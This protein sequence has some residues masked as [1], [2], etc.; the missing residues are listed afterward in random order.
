MTPRTEKRRSRP[1]LKLREVLCGRG[2]TSR[3]DGGYS[4]ETVLVIALLAVLA[5]GAVTIISQAVLS[6]AESIALD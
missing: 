1:L 5:I 4:T 6:K 2:R 3:R